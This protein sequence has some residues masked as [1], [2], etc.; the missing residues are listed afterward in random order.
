ME[1]LEDISQTNYYI[2]WIKMHCLIHDL[3]NVPSTFKRRFL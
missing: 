1:Y 2:T 3:K